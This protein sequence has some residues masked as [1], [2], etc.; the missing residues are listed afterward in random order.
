[1]RSGIKQRTTADFSGGSA[2][3]PAGIVRLK[4]EWV[5]GLSRCFCAGVYD[6]VFSACD[7][8]LDARR[9][10]GGVVEELWRS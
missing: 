8:T 3:A 10:R 5:M 4:Y 7:E 2:L 1:M 9:L 6:A